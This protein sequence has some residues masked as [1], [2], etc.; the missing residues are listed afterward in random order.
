[1]VLKEIV[2]DLLS[3]KCDVV[4]VQVNCQGTMN[5]GVIKAIR[6]KH[7]LAYEQYSRFLHNNV[8]V[9]DGVKKNTREFLGLCQISKAREDKYIALLYGQDMY[10]TEEGKQYTDYNALLCSLF[11][12]RR[13]VLFGDYD[14]NSIA[15]PYMMGCG[16][17]GGGDWKK[18]R[19]MIEA[20]FN[21][22]DIE[23]EIRKINQ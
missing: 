21:D 20:V 8:R 11:A 3:S 19:E 9:E 1:M 22:L 18:I 15:F 5:Y 12:L 16:K 13:L 2:G 14:I 6:R 17:N 23:I 7:P 4:C 10:G